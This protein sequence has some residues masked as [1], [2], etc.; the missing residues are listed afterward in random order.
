M[1]IA[2][3]FIDSPE[4]H[5]A[6]DR[7]IEEAQLRNG[8][9]LIINS[10]I[11]GSHDD[12]GVFIDMAESLKNLEAQLAEVGVPYEIHEFVRGQKPAQDIIDAVADH[13]AEMIIIGIRKRS[14]TG[15]MLLGSNA[16]DILHDAT[17]P[18]LCVKAP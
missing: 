4:G 16:L 14:A 5:A 2:V 12:A 10:K 18:V 11:G 9:L 1:K 6:I 8:N 3:G 13:G 7:A 17:V 15:K